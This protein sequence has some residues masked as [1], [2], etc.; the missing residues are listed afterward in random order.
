MR[1]VTVR[2]I[3]GTTFK[4]PRKGKV[5]ERD[6]VLSQEETEAILQ[7]NLHRQQNL[8][9]QEVKEPVKVDNRAYYKSLPTVYDFWKDRKL[10]KTFNI[11]THNK[12]FNK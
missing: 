6:H 9:L 1:T 7:E 3:D 5:L 11:I 12:N 2:H 10:A 8:P 4:A